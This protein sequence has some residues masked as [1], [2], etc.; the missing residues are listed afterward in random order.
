MDDKLIDYLSLL[1][2]IQLTEEEKKTYGS[3]MSDIFLWVEQIKDLNTGEDGDLSYKK[4]E[5][6][7]R[8]D[9]PI[10]FENRK[11]IIDNFTAREFDF[12]K[13]KKVIEG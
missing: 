12:L 6:R 4:E 13:V 5:G 2:R 9:I 3:Q 1:S 10:P 11:A 7:L 8:Q